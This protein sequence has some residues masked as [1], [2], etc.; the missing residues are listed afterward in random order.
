MIDWENI[1]CQICGEK[2]KNTKQNKVFYE[3]YFSKPKK[4]IRVFY[5]TNHAVPVYW[6]V[7]IHEVKDAM[8]AIRN[9]I[10]HDK[11]PEKNS[12]L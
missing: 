11:L 9:F 3:S 6:S 5:C 1:H 2:R 4:G 7:E 12:K 8:K 10:F